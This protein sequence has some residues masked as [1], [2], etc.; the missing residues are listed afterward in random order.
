MGFPSSGEK[1]DDSP[2]VEGPCEG[3]Y[4]LSF[5][6]V[7][8]SGEI[9]LPGRPYSERDEAPV[10]NSLLKPTMATYVRDSPLEG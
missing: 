10:L 2:V 6:N 8:K 4:E 1:G 7:S 5:D 9:V 3:A